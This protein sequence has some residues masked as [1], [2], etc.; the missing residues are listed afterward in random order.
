ME[1]G[2]KFL[3]GN[4]PLS[5]LPLF[6]S[7]NETQVA[8]KDH[9]KPTSELSPIQVEN[10]LN[11]TS[12]E[13][14]TFHLKV[15]D[16]EEPIE[17][18]LDDGATDGN[19]ISRKIVD[20]FVI[21]LRQVDK[22]SCK[23]CTGFSN[24]CSTCE[25]IADIQISFYDEITESKHPFI[26]IEAKVIDTPFDLIIGKYYNIKYNLSNKLR[27]QFQNSRL[28]ISPETSDFRRRRDFA[29]MMPMESRCERVATF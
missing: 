24:L 23:I 26:A 16:R 28:M 19:Y 20:R 15:M 13:T 29:M 27:Y 12:R 17:V 1:K 11:F 2:E 7:P 25:G 9:S 3:P 10:L 4:K 14:I 21:N 18:L 22:N 8:K 6:P 5:S